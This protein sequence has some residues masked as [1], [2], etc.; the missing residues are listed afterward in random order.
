MT[1]SPNRPLPL[2]C[3]LSDGD[4]PC[5]RG[6]IAS[7]RRFGLPIL[8]GACT[9]GQNGAPADGV[10]TA[11]IAW[12]DDFA[13][14]RNQ[15]AEIALARHADNPYLL[16][17][18]S[19]EELVSWPERDWGRETAPWF[20]LQIQDTDA[21]TPRPITRLQRNDAALCWRD[22][23][24]E[25]LEAGPRQPVVQP[26]APPQP[27]MGAALRH[28]GY[29]DDR[30]ISAKLRR[31]R[32]IVAAERR[33]GRDYLN[34]WVEEAR[35]AEAFGTG[36]AMAWAKV[37]NHP[38]AAPRRAGAIDPRVEAA[39]SLCEFGNSAPAL[40]LLAA[41][42]LIISL[43]LAI[44]CGQQAHGQPLDTARLDFLADCTRAGLGDWR[45]SYP[46]ALLAASRDKILALVKDMAEA[47]AANGKSKAAKPRDRRKEMT[48]RF[49]QSEN[50]DAE[51][52]GEDLVLM[53]S[54]TREVVTLNP[55]A[56]VVWECLAD[57][58]SVEE[59]AAS[60]A[61]AFPDIDSTVLHED[62][63]RTLD[64]LVAS[65]LALPAGDAA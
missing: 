57:G 28:H 54:R 31:N 18:D 8:I 30:T 61:G 5:L 58:L 60:F 65:G 47:I 26:L 16:W 39:V 38:Q 29:R 23:I 44:L 3:I 50:H 32:D 62:I 34:L 1:D 10:S 40:S 7:V 45:Y 53:N 51:I 9:G 19:D 4:G 12:R 59:I 2:V 56:R 6:A 63:A 48:S 43:Q 25:T 20:T 35:Y 33:Q 41:N 13:A 46:R 15:L 11:A 49:I 42:P 52:L 14:A 21:L 17:L 27:L 24:H 36:A 22:A 55:T 37:F 64:H